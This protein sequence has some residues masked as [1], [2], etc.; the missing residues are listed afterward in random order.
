MTSAV[1]TTAADVALQQFRE[2]FRTARLNVKQIQEL[3]GFIKQELL[4]G[5]TVPLI[6]QAVE[7]RLRFMIHTNHLPNKPSSLPPPVH[8]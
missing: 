8:H 3:E 6:K 1:D 4:R 5:T 2:F 7:V